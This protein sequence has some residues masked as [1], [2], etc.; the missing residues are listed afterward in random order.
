MGFFVWL[1]SVFLAVGC[2]YLTVRIYVLINIILY[3]VVKTQNTYYTTR[4]LCLC[5]GG[6]TVVSL[7]CPDGNS[8]GGHTL[9]TLP[10]IVT[11]YRDSVNGTCARVTYQKLVTQ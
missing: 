10:R 7:L 2:S 6:L 1:S 4:I 8:K 9:V 11:T 3:K 5:L